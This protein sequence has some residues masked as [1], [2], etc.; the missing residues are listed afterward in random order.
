MFKRVLREELRHHVDYISDHNWFLLTDLNAYF[1]VVAGDRRF[2]ANAVLMP[3]GRVPG[4]LPLRTPMP[5]TRDVYGWSIVSVRAFSYP[6]AFFYVRLPDWTGITMAA[7]HFGFEL[8]HGEDSGLIDFLYS[9]TGT[10]RGRLYAVTKAGEE[11][12]DLTPILPPNA[13]TAMIEY[14]I[15]LDRDSAW[16]YVDYW[17]LAPKGFRPV[18]VVLFTDFPFPSYI[19][20]PPPYGIAVGYR[21]RPLTHSPLLIELDDD[22]RIGL[23]VSSHFGWFPYFPSV[24]DGDPKPPRAL[25]LYQA[26]SWSTFRGSS[27]SSGSLTSHPIPVYGYGKWELLVDADQDFTVELQYLAPSGAWRTFDTYPSPTGARRLH[28]L[29][30]EPLILARVVL[31]PATYPATVNDAFV[32]MI[33]GGD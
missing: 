28:L 16:F 13:W 21:A 25:E 20:N 4:F 1:A 5:T 7:L 27:I 30:D 8:M 14:A 12:I 2:D 26:N 15:K 32:V 23:D 29:V 22:M 11:L 17:D 31:T 9:A 18:A 24:R 3:D 33:P 6:M 19:V 10:D